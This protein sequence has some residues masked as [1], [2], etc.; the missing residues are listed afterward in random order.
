MSINEAVET[1]NQICSQTRM[2]FIPKNLDY[3]RA[4]GRLSNAAYFGGRLLNI[5]PLVEI[6]NGVLTATKKYRGDTKI[7]APRLIKEYSQ[8]QN[9]SKDLLYLICS[10]GLDDDLKII[11]EKE[12]EK[13]GFKKVV[14]LCTGC[15]ITTH[16]G[17]GAFGVVGFSENQ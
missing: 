13:C 16:G 8:E 14:W 7:L 11:A 3:L 1:A 9:L 12:A 4:G 2:C 15:V 6:L 10:I 17:P 5:H